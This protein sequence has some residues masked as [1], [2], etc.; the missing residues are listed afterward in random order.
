MAH[1]DEHRGGA[2]GRGVAGAIEQ[3]KVTNDAVAYI[4]SL[5]EATGRNADWAEQAVRESVSISAEEA[6]RINVADRPRALER[7]VAAGARRRDADGGRR[8]NR[9]A[10]RQH[11]TPQDPT[12]CSMSWGPAPAAQPVRP[13][14]GVPVLLP[15]LI[16]IVVE[17]LHPGISG[18]RVA[19]H[20]PPGDERLISFGL[21]PVRLGGVVLLIASAVFFLLE[22]K[23]PPWVSGLSPP[24]AA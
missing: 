24:W 3:T 14:P 22:F 6:V 10:G 4:R 9:D 15:G 13:R 17:L 7:S 2:P 19:R 5:A 11:E 23:H 18:A 12:T 8:T 21:L 1:G 16:L 20:D